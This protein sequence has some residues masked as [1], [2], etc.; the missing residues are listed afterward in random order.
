MQLDRRPSP[1][2]GTAS[3]NQATAD[4]ARDTHVTL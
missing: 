3:L 4:S 1:N 2:S